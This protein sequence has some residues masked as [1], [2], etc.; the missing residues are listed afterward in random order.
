MELLVEK[1]II[2]SKLPDKDEVARFSNNLVQGIGLVNKYFYFTD[3]FENLNHY[4][5][6]IWHKWKANLIQNYFSNPWSVISF[7]AASIP[8][9][10]TAIQ[11]VYS[12]I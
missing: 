12:I 9:I 8:L 4:Y 7:I 2:D 5:G 6:I 10:L 3:L 11:T 1:G